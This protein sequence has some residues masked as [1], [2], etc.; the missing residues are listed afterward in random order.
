M[1]RENDIKRRY[2]SD[3]AKVRAEKKSLVDQLEQT[4]QERNHAVQER[5]TL[6]QERNA[7]ALQCQQEFE[8]A[9]KYRVG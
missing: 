9:E 1:S 8:R 7:L 4:L 3:L 2:D 6:I 5:N